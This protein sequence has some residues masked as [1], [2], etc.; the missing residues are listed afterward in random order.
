MDSINKQY[1]N[2]IRELIVIT[3]FFILG[4]NLTMGLIHVMLVVVVLP[5]PF[6]GM[7]AWKNSTETQQSGHAPKDWTRGQKWKKWFRR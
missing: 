7:R 5:N 6:R 1:T 4:L 3:V 2:S